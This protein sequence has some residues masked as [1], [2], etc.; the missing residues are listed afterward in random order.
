[1]PNITDMQAGF[2][3]F[4][5]S[6]VDVNILGV[7]W[8]VSIILVL[9]SLAIITRQFAKWKYL[10]LP[11]TLMWDIAGTTPTAI[12]YA[13]CVLFFV[14]EL[15]SLEV[16]VEPIR[17][18]GK[19]FDDRQSAT[20]KAINEAIAQGK[21]ARQKIKSERIELSEQERVP[22]F[23]SSNILQRRAEIEA[24]KSARAQIEKEK[25][26]TEIITGYKTDREGNII[27]KE[28]KKIYLEPEKRKG[29]LGRIDNKIKGQLREPKERYNENVWK[30]RTLMEGYS[31][32]APFFKAGKSSDKEAKWNKEAWARLAE[33][34]KNYIPE[35]YIGKPKVKREEYIDIKRITNLMPKQRTSKGIKIPRIE[36]Y[37]K[38]AFGSGTMTGL[39]EFGDKVQTKIRIKRPEDEGIYPEIGDLSNENNYFR[40][41]RKKWK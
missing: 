41:L 12:W 5:T 26:M 29:L 13:I 14:I 30:A 17:A 4:R 19:Q 16:I 27:G 33:K 18:L 32:D 6:F 3:L 34:G 28:T 38:P 40:K 10:A 39:K 1:M 9:L 25:R 22:W 8:A 11:V 23:R 2:D 24:E 20:R 36:T 37:G 35:T 31:E 7:G 15:M 21:S